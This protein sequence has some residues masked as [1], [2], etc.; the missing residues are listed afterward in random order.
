MAKAHKWPL[1]SG[2]GWEQKCLAVLCLVD[3]HQQTSFSSP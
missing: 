1:M 2:H 3:D